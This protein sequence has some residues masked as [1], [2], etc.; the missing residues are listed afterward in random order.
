[1]KN[2]LER[3]SNPLL[4]AILVLCRI[5]LSMIELYLALPLKLFIYSQSF[6]GVLESVRGLL[7]D[8]LEPLQ[9]LAQVIR[10]EI[11][12]FGG[13][14]VCNTACARH[15]FM[16]GSLSLFKARKVLGMWSNLT[17]SSKKSRGPP[18]LIDLLNHL[19][20]RLQNKMALFFHHAIYHRF[21]QAGG[22]TRRVRFDDE[23]QP[24][25]FQA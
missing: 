3:S 21:V 22:S 12:A 10:F 7:N 13:L 9:G 14:M 20:S 19:A 6:E 4:G 25:Y 24:E 5:R 18:H 11:Q 17:K 16:Q 2:A 15:D 23:V 8:G 1:M